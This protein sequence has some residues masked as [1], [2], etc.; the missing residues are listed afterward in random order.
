MRP[1][2]HIRLSDAD[3]KASRKWGASMMIAVIL[4][5]GAAFLLPAPRGNVAGTQ[6]VLADNSNPGTS[7][8]TPD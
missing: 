4:V 3:R 1:R 6:P 2:I 8:P 5:A 7:S